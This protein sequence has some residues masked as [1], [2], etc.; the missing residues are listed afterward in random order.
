MLERQWANKRFVAI[1]ADSNR[2]E[3]Q[4][5][6]TQRKTK[7]VLVCVLSVRSV[8]KQLYQRVNQAFKF[9]IH[10]A[11]KDCQKITNTFTYVKQ[12]KLFDRASHLNRASETLQTNGQNLRHP[13]RISPK[14]LLWSCSVCSQ[15]KRTHWQ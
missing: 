6:H 10:P 2:V 5:D 14:S 11:A 4:R 13:C 12:Q 1:K 9:Q 8:Q 7:C 15:L 3:G